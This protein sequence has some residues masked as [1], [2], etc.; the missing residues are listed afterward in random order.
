MGRQRRIPAVFMRGGTSKGIFFCAEDL[1]A[2]RDLWDAVFAAALGSPDPYGRQL[3]G[4]GGGV[5][6]LS[7]VMI[8]ERP[9][10]AE[11]ALADVVYTFVQVPVGGGPLDYSGNCGNL[12]AAV[13]PFAVDCGLITAADGELTVRL[14]NRNTG[15]IV[16]SRFRV[17][18]GEAAVLGRTVIPGVAGQGAPVFLDFDAPAG[19]VTGALLPTGSP[20]DTLVLDHGRSITVSCVD[21]SNP[22]VF[23]EGAQLGLK[24]IPTVASLQADSDLMTLL[25]RVRRLGG[26]RMRLAQSPGR[27]ALSAPKIALLFAPSDVPGMALGGL[28]AASMDILAIALSMEKVHAALPVTTALCLA[29]AACVPGT[30]PARLA[31][32]REGQWMRIGNPAGVLVTEAHVTWRDGHWTV[33]SAGLVRTARRLMEGHVCIPST[34]P[35]EAP[36][37]ARVVAAPSAG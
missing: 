30:V 33:Q 28:S 32:R 11:S 2:D 37:L 3:D 31:R 5:S 14:L 17:V 10:G 19:A 21:A 22:V 9:T 20:T 36:E 24:Q 16:R 23:V 6:S 25:D 12:T 35:Q 18:D 8:V 29:V 27:V 13:G 4:L 1:P 34:G 15:K 7:K 26:V